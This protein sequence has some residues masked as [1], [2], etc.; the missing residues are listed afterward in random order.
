MRA[1]S[2]KLSY[3]EKETQEMVHEM[4]DTLPDDQRMC[5]LMFH[6]E[7]RVFVKLRRQWNVR[8]IP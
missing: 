4:L 2:R 6:F 1:A 3:T 5:I 7:G 8:K